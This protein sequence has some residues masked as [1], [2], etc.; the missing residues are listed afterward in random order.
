M[1]KLYFNT[2]WTDFYGWKVK[3][4]LWF[5]LATFSI[6]IIAVVSHN[7]FL[8]FICSISGIAGA[9]LIA[10]GKISGYLGG[11]INS[12]TYTLVS[13]KFGLY[14]ETIVYALLFV[15]M[16][17]IGFYIW[18]KNS[19]AEGEKVDVIKKTLTTK[20]RVA[21]LLGIAA[22]VALY[23]FFISF[24]KGSMPGLD[25]ATA[26]LS[27]VATTLMM[28]RYAEQWIVWITVNVIAVTM[29]IIAVLNNDYQGIA[30]LAM[31][32]LFL[33]NSIYGWLNWKKGGEYV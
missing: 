5:A 20:K 30:I 2:I 18:A 32:I 10:K 33:L 27:I 12:L 22:T 14:G 1:K 25:C 17:F 6:V 31:W 19:V 15:P 23:S 3:E 29:W 13:Y 7:S 16:Q 28:L 8:E 26:I 21:L 9:I 4:Y 24:L 11:I